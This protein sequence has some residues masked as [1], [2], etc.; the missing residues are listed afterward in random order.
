MNVDEISQ[1]TAKYDERYVQHR[2]ASADDVTKFAAV[3][4]RDVA[5]IYDVLTRLRNLERNPTGFA[6][7]DAPVLGLLVRMWKLLKEIIR[8]YEQ[9]NAEIIGVL[10]RPFLEAAV[11]ATFL[12][13]STDAVIEDYR[14]C[15][16]RHR[17][18]LLRESKAGSKFFE[19]KAGRRLIKSIEEKMAFEKLTESNFDTQ[20]QNRWH[21]QGMSFFEIF[22][23]VHGKDLYAMTYGIMSESIHGSWNDS[24][25]FCLL[26]NEDG[27]FYPNPFFQSADMRF[28]T[29][30][31]QFS[32]PAYRLWLQRIDAYDENHRGLLVWIDRVNR[33][34]FTKFDA[35]F[36]GP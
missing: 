21:I 28:I 10:D 23:K 18:R 5:E 14:K 29:P 1:I 2:L 36:D 12:L 15:S 11:T 8:Y 3:F 20:Q 25:D 24:M 32:Q 13:E 7:G 22:G 16:Y 6:I 19:T 4:Y 34:V 27:T 31:L 26:K 17:L 30:L 9:N 33:A 35:A